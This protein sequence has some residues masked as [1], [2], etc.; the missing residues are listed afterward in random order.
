MNAP[1]A[2]RRFIIVTLHHVQ[3]RSGIV[4]NAVTAC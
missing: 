4:K 3:R 2:T 1:L